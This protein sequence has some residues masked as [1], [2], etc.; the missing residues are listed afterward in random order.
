MPYLA[1]PNLNILRSG[2]S[3][4]DLSTS[5]CGTRALLRLPEDADVPS[6][7]LSQ[8]LKREIS[9]ADAV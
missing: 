1:V 6:R 5:E 8:D 4:K 3:R 7:A 9:E 2:W